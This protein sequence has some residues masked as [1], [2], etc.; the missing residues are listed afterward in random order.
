MSLLKVD[1]ITREPVLFGQDNRFM[2]LGEMKAR[3]DIFIVFI[4]VTTGKTYVEEAFASWAGG[5]KLTMLDEVKDDQLWGLLTEAAQKYGLCMVRH[6]A[7]NLKKVNVK[8][9]EPIAKVL[10]L[11]PSDMNYLK[12]MDVI[13]TK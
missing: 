4:D 1:L 9:L 12:K 5:T 3:G 7:D 11:L 6:I 2:T 13:R 10:C 8:I